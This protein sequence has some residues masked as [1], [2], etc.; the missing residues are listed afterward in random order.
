MTRSINEKDSQI[1]QKQESIF[2]K[3]RKEIITNHNG[4]KRAQ[5]VALMAKFPTIKQI[6]EVGAKL[7]KRIDMTQ[8]EEIQELEKQKEESI[9]KAKLRIIAENEDE[10]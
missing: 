7:I 9:E 4:I 6:Q 10:L 2:F 5:V 8:E 1:R 3:E